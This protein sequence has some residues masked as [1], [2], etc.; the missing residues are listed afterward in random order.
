MKW[1]KYSLFKWVRKYNRHNRQKIRRP[2]SHMIIE[3]L[4]IYNIKI[5]W[6]IAIKIKKNITTRSKCAQIYNNFD[7]TVDPWNVFEPNEILIRVFKENRNKCPYEKFNAENVYKIGYLSV[8]IHI[9]MCHQ[10]CHYTI[11][12]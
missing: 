3:F 10:T 9:H 12:Q 7:E 8:K 1:L 5:S 6:Q 11:L 4:S 2:I